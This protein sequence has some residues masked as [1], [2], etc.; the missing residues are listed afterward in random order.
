MNR[1]RYFTLDTD[2]FSPTLSLPLETVNACLTDAG[3]DPDFAIDNLRK[4]DL[5]VRRLGWS[6]HRV[7]KEN[8][9]TVVAESRPRQHSG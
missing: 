1:P 5:L 4:W 2:T 9:G 7:Q 3:F 8:S 6:A